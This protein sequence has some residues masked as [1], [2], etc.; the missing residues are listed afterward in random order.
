MPAGS[1]Y[2]GEAAGGRIIRTAVGVGQIGDPYQ[3]ELYT[4]DDRPLGNDGEAV[5]RWLTVLLRHT[6]GYNVSVQP[7]VDGV[8]LN[9]GTF[10]AGPPP[11]SA[12]EEVARLRV[13]PLA[14]GNRIGAIVKTVALL[15]PTEVVDVAYGYVAIRTGR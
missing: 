15:G 12:L 3:L 13:W 8:P 10:S 11:A 7:V 2:L 9:S 5:F 6:L 4:W 1:L 14:R